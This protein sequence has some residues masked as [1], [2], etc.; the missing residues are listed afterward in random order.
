GE[1]AL[2]V[3]QV[4]EALLHVE[5]ERV[6]DLG[7][8]LL[9]LQMREERVAAAIPDAEHELVPDGVRLADLGQL[10]GRAVPAREAARREALLVALDVPLACL[11]VALEA[12]E[13]DP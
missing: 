2:L 5:G 3:P 12:R 10:E 13:L 7:P 6:V 1:R 9:L 4:L 11:R 8:D